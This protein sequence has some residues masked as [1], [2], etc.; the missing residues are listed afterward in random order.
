MTVKRRESPR[1]A[2]PPLPGTYPQGTPWN[3][4]HGPHAWPGD[5]PAT[6]GADRMT[7]VDQTF[8]KYNALDSACMMDIYNA[9]KSDVD[10][11][12]ADTYAL[13][14]DVF[15]VLMFMQ[16]RG[17]RVSHDLL[18]Q[19]K[20]DVLEKIKQKQ[21]ELD[22][23][24]GHHLNVDSPKQCC[25]YFYIEQDVK[26]YLNKA[27]RPTVDDK[28]LQRLVRATST[29]RA[30]P[31]AKLIQDIRGLSKLHGTYLDIEFD[32]DNR[33]RGSYN[34]R[35]TKF[36]R[37]S[38]SKTVFGTGMNF[39]NLPQDFKKFLIPDPGYAFIELDKRQAEWVVVAY[40]SGDAN[41]ISAIE[42]GE[43]VHVHTASLMYGVDGETV[44]Y[45]NK[46]IGHL[47]DPE[48][49]RDIRESDHRLTNLIGKF[50]RTMSARQAGKKS[51]HGLNYDEGYRGFS[52]INEIPE[53][54]GKKMVDT[55]HKIYP[56]IRLWY[57]V[58][59]RQLGKDRML[60]NY[61]GRRVRFIGQWGDDLFKSAYSM[62]PQST[63]VD[64]LNGGMAKIYDDLWITKELNLDILAQVHDSVLM[65]IPIKWLEDKETYNKLWGRLDDYTSPQIEYNGREFKIASD[66]K[67]SC[68][69]WGGHHSEHNPHG[70]QDVE[71]HADVLKIIKN[72]RESCGDSGTE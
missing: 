20:L 8:L 17:V 26:P 56:G 29:R 39:Q 58:I 49:I 22:E 52:L 21:A 46:L 6:A 30:F 47:T 2:D 18:Q 44:R 13:T 65:Q 37:L 53:S 61:F 24:V 7:N 1:M 11:T 62:I 66:L 31:E 59:K 5:A 28:A 64:S 70:M 32:E 54:E 35:G 50:P 45:D 36:G 42:R 67:M 23:L 68:S 4:R 34:P 16:T 41:M 55:Y 60:E 69:N 9:I 38:S 40:A 14:M 3:G 12:F 27:G 72:W 43:D 25:N 33:M 71:T 15:P 63:V 10:A 19:T 48:A 57:E 51:N